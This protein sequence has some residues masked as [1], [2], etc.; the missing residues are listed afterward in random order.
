MRVLQVEDVLV[1]ADLFTAIATNL[2]HKVT[3]V[4]TL[5]EATARFGVAQRVVVPPYDLVVLDLCLP[6]SVADMTCVAIRRFSEYVPVLVVSALDN[7]DIAKAS[8]RLGGHSYLSKSNY[9]LP[10]VERA[11][12]ASIRNRN[13]EEAIRVANSEEE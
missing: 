5:A 13:R 8:T 6:D 4:G 2:G 11:I 1:V 10:D 3:T 9:S 12:A 7:I